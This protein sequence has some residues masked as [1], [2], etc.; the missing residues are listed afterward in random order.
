M[1][2]H[3]LSVDIGGR[4]LSIETGKIARQASGSVVVRQGDSAVLVT[5]HADTRPDNRDFIPLSCEFRE[6]NGAYGTIPGNFFKREGRPN[7]R[8][9]I[10]AHVEIRNIFKISRYGTIA[11]CFVRSGTIERSNKIRVSRDGAV[12]YTGE[13]DSLKRFKDD[14]KEVREGFECGLHINGYNDIKVGD[15]IEAYK[16]EQV[17]RTLS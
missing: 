7:E 3:T 8:E 16:I 1:S 14:A 4:P 11:G 15:T 13:L 9:T 10:T 12:I 5:A 6:R 2:I 17:A